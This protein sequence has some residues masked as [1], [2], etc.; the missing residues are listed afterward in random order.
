MQS[1]RYLVG[2]YKTLRDF[3]EKITQI[4]MQLG[5]RSAFAYANQVLCRTIPEAGDLTSIE[6]ESVYRACF[7]ERMIPLLSILRPDC[8]LVMGWRNDGSGW[9]QLY[10]APL[11]EEAQ[12]K[13]LIAPGLNYIGIPQT[14]RP[15]NR[16][17]AVEMVR[18][19]LIARFMSTNVVNE[20]PRNKDS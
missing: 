9:S 18:E 12:K 7:S 17:R 19:Y 14:S 16:S 3:T 11:F 5:K 8:V 2:Q 4:L 10:F 15:N 13:K 20:K 1:I 6:L